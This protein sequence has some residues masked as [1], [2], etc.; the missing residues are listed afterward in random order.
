MK[1]LKKTAF[2]ELLIRQNGGS[3]ILQKVV[4]DVFILFYLFIFCISCLFVHSLLFIFGKE[5]KW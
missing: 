1:V 4:R 3:R 5:I 2:N